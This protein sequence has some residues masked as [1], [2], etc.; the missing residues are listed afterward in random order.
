M[1]L[2]LEGVAVG[3]HEVRLEGSPT[4]LEWLAQRGASKSCAEALSFAQVWRPV[5]V[6]SENWSSTLDL[7]S[8]AA[9]KPRK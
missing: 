9:L 7:A 2:I 3:H 1:R 5:V 4:V 6:K 8:F